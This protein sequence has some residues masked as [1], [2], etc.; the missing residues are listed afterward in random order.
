M[1]GS[2]KYVISLK[3]CSC[4]ESISTWSKCVH[5]SSS[6]RFNSHVVLYFQD[7][8]EVNKAGH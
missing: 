5:L 2:E 3:I 6:H 7:W 4:L 1:S 8:R